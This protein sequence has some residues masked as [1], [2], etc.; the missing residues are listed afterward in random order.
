MLQPKATQATLC[1]LPTK[2]QRVG[3]QLSCGAF[4]LLLSPNKIG[5]PTATAI[6]Q[7]KNI[8]ANISR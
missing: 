5:S 6:P 8:E 3:T 2:I 4:Y 1:K 7:I